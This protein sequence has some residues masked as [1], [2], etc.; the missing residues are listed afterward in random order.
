ML[1]S[2]TFT[3]EKL[4]FE[5]ISP[6]DQELID[7]AEYSLAH[8]MLLKRSYEQLKKFVAGHGVP[9]PKV[10]LQLYQ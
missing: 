5:R 4:P 9:L 1:I 2:K 7:Q 6:D 8:C 3:L 10:L